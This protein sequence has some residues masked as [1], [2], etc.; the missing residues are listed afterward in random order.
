MKDLEIRAATV[1]QAIELALE[2]L[3]L[4]REEVK[5]TVVQEGKADV[6]GIGSEDAI[7]KVTPLSQ[8]NAE[9]DEVIKVARSTA[10]EILKLMGIDATIK[11]ESPIPEETSAATL[12]I[13]GDDLGILIGRRGQTLSSLQQIIRLITSHHLKAWIP[14]SI[15]VE[16]YRR[17]RY[18]T[19]R[20][21][22][23]RLAE[24]VKETGEEITLEPMPASERRI[25]HLTLADSPDVTTHSVGWGEER[26]ITIYP[27]ED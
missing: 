24:Q 18:A 10:E 3:G 19:L 11:V 16:G 22:A 5:I 14:L 25:V 7:V 8:L 20:R 6:L 17:R 21:L 4:D 27:K 12:N 2:Q 26:K 23:L 1:E 15:D 9:R 13:I